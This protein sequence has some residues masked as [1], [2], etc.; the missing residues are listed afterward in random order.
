MS[1]SN[2]LCPCLHR[3]TYFSFNFSTVLTTFPH[4]QVIFFIT[5][6]FTAKSE[7]IWQSCW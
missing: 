2:N 7:N 4:S 6:D 3:L 5:A 1:I